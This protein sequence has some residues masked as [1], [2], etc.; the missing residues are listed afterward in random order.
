MRDELKSIKKGYTWRDMFFALW[1]V[2]TVKYVTAGQL[3]K[4]YPDNLWRRKCGTEGKLDLFVSV[5]LLRRRDNGVYT[6]TPKTIE[7]LR[8]ELKIWKEE[9]KAK[10]ELAEWRDE[11]LLY[12]PDII[13]LGTGEGKKDTLYNSDVLL[14]AMKRRD[15]LA[16]FYHTF[17]DSKGS[18]W[19]TPDGVM[20]LRR[21]NKLILIFLE[22]EKEK[23]LW[24]D[25]IEGKKWKYEKLA[26]EEWIWSHWWRN[27][28]EQLKINHC[29]KE[30]FGFSVWCIG[31]IRQDDWHGWDFR[32]EIL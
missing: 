9:R 18:P 15:F 20:L 23:P 17:S 3:K 13:E 5:G 16:V 25:H 4:Y 14:Q 24:R 28:C 11:E 12:N 27:K 30:E 31:D 8:S 1:H 6:A 19:L 26:Q 7:F 21:K 10:N 2:A 32:S 22:I 29:G